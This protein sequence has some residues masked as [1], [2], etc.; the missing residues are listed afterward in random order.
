MSLT[1]RD[2]PFSDRPRER[3]EK[4]GTES[5]SDAELLAIVIRSGGKDSN[6]LSLSQQLLSTFHGL[7]GLIYADYSSLRKVRY[8]GR[9]KVSCIKAI[10]E[11]VR[12]SISMEV[13]DRPKISKAQVAYE[14]VR[15]HILGK[16][17]ECL[18]L[19]ALDFNSHLLRLV[20]LSTGTQSQSL[21]DPREVLRSA[22][23]NDA[24]SIVLVHNHPSGNP[25]PSDEDRR[26]TRILSLAAA[27]V[28]VIF[29]DHIIITS[30]NYFSFKNS[31]LLNLNNERR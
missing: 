8:V 27:Q 28:G 11:I 10:G 17:K 19:L 1:L 30:D 2:I 7:R 20:L 26:I 24:S 14:L 22:L 29:L 25:A 13:L 6:V 16:D 18:Y 4:Y 9:A 3:L 23:V 15:P 31:G 21:V 12:R 5:L